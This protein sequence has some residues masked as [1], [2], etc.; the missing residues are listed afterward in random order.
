MRVS[1]SAAP[2]LHAASPAAHSL[3]LAGT[4]PVSCYA[5]GRLC[6]HSHLPS[7]HG[8]RPSGRAGSRLREL[9]AD[10]ADVCS[11]RACR[12]RGSWVPHSLVQSFVRWGAGGRSAK[13]TFSERQGDPA[14]VRG[15]DHRVLWGSARA[16]VVASRASL[17]LPA[18]SDSNLT[19]ASVAPNFRVCP[20]SAPQTPKGGK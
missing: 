20:K 7:R 6:G 15:A 2:R 4:L 12:V 16:S 3:A 14:I 9:D 11:P 8:S 13:A 17:R 18:K 5:R 10:H 19:Q 1:A